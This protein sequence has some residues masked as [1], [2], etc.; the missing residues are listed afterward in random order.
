[1]RMTLEIECVNI[2]LS[3]SSGSSVI[4][5]NLVKQLKDKI[6]VGFVAGKFL[7]NKKIKIIIKHHV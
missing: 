7:C 6:E 3:F 2:K 5:M 4:Y 1:M